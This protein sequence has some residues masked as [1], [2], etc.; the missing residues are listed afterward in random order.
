MMKEKFNFMKN[1]LLVLTILALLGVVAGCVSVNSEK[2]EDRLSALKGI[3]EEEDLFDAIEETQY[4]DIRNLAASRI[5]REDLSLRLLKRDDLLETVRTAL[6]KNVKDE[7]ELSALVL[8]QDLPLACRKAALGAIE[9]NSHFLTFLQVTPPLEDWIREKAIP[10]VSDQPTLISIFRDK[11]STVFVRELAL[12]RIEKKEEILLVIM[13]RSDDDELRRKSFD[14]ILLIDASARELEDNSHFL[15]FLQV[16][17]PLEDWIREKA[18]PRVSDQPTLISIFRDK[19]STV[20]IRKLALERI[21]KEEDVLPVIMDR[22]DD[23][24]LRR[25]AVEKIY[26]E[27]SARV[28]LDKSPILEEWACMRAISLVS[29][30][31]KLSE[32]FLDRQ[33]YDQVRL[34]AGDKISSSRKMQELFLASTDDLAARLS[35]RKMDKVGV[36]EEKFQQRLLKL[37]RSTSNSS[38][39]YEAWR[40]LD[41]K[42]DFCLENDQRRIVAILKIGANESDVDRMLQSLLTIVASLSWQPV[43]TNDWPKRRSG[44]NQILPRHSKLRRGHGFLPSN[45]RHCPSWKERKTSRELQSL[46]RAGMSA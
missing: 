15:T 18:I 5:R 24:E 35:L 31:E 27:A 43:T 3:T 2:F 25:M 23:D 12:E 17:P 10:R 32:V 22:S 44:C 29:D 6:V 28:I 33:F 26:T 45:V 42:T 21:G 14:K 20:F 40:Y 38:L 9:D 16:T 1:K 13:D 8:D 30:P 41:P 34:T 46:E 19:N 39:M 11:N 4:N 36:H 37:F 7:T